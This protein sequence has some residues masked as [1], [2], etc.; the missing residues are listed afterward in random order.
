ML[1]TIYNDGFT[2]G[3]II[4]NGR[5]IRD[6]RD[7]IAKVA[8]KSGAFEYTILGKKGICMNMILGGSPWFGELIKEYDFVCSF[9]Y[10]GNTKLY[11]YSFYSDAKRGCSCI[12]LAQH[13][14]EKGGGHEHAA[15]CTTKNFIFK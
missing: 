12:K 8:C 3:E 13:I 15:G 4:S 10:N 1:D 11:E 2:T 5:I 14:D 9:F 6:Y 7:S